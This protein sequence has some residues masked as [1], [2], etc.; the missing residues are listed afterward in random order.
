MAMVTD[1]ATPQLIVGEF[2]QIKR[3]NVEA[4]RAMKVAVLLVCEYII[5]CIARRV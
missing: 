5:A 2:V 4:I 1:E 3:W